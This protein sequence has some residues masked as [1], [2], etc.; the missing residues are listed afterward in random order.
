VPKP[1]DAMTKHLRECSISRR[2]FGP[3]PSATLA[4]I[5]RGTS[6]ECLE[7]LTD[8]LLDATSWDDLLA[9]R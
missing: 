8:R 6:Q 1:F 2:D 7:R 4:E 9:T 3:V 5:E